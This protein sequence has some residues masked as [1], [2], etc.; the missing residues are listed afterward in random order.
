MENRLWPD[1]DLICDSFSPSGG[2]S[3]RAVE[4]TLT[5]KV[6][7]TEP[8]I[9]SYFGDGIPAALHISATRLVPRPHFS[10][11]P[12]RWKTSAMIGLRNRGKWKAARQFSCR[13][14]AL[15]LARLS[16]L[17]PLSVPFSS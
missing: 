11:S 9:S 10:I 17:W 5:L 15:L 6:T 12:A 16:P 3:T 1:S 8:P 7:T 2:I 14:A 13:T 4:P